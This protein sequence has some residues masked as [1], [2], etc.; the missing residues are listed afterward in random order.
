[1]CRL[2]DYSWVELKLNFVWKMIID[3]NLFPSDTCVQLERRTFQ[4]KWLYNAIPGYA[5]F[6]NCYCAVRYSWYWL[7]ISRTDECKP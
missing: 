7:V 4:T 2:A 6:T 1:M 5:L 3:I